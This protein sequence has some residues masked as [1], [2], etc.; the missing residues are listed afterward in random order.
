MH[1]T[2]KNL[3]STKAFLFA[4]HLLL[5]HKPIGGNLELEN[6]RNSLH[7]QYPPKPL[8]I[9]LHFPSLTFSLEDFAPLPFSYFSMHYQTWGKWV[10]DLTPLTLL[11]VSKFLMQKGI[12][13]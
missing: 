2:V 3:G 9:K 4:K 10:R 5:R 6:G 12:P 11:K 1:G 13:F 7:L 8:S